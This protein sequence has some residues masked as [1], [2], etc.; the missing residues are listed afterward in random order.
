MSLLVAL[1]LNSQMLA[2]EVMMTFL[3]FISSMELEACATVVT[4]QEFV[5]LR[6]AVKTKVVLAIVFFDLVIW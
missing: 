5:V 4:E 3:L 2:A 6:G 1:V